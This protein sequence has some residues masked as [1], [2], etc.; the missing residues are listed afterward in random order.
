[1]DIKYLLIIPN[2]YK[3]SISIGPILNLI[4]ISIESNCLHY[5]GLS[6]LLPLGADLTKCLCL[7]FY[8]LFGSCFSANKL[9]QKENSIKSA[10]TIFISLNV[11]KNTMPIHSEHSVF[12]VLFPMLTEFHYKNDPYLSP[13]PNL[14]YS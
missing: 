2:G 8:C 9:L 13:S 14:Y 1:M 11:K 3:I 6:L 10:I 7:F 4:L 5:H 12:L